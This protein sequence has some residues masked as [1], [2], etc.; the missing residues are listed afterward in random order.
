MVSAIFCKNRRSWVTRTMA[1]LKSANCSSRNSI[2]GISRWLVGS[3]KNRMSGS[4]TKALASATRRFHP[5]ERSRI[6]LSPSMPSRVKIDS[7]CWFRR[8]PSDVSIISC[9]RCSLGS[10]ASVAVCDRVWYSDSAGPKSPKPDATTSKQV[11]SLAL[12]MSCSSMP[13]FVAG[14]IQ[15][16]PLSA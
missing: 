2:V 6:S 13:S 3:S 12:G 8:Q 7:T 16:S 14:R 5:P 15:R 9:K 1:P 10:S 11:A 4:L